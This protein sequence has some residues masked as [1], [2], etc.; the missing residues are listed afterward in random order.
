MTED[1][2]SFELSKKYDIKK[3][4]TDGLRFPKIT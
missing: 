4:Y 3:T 1:D 2:V